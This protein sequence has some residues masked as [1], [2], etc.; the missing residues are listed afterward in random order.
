MAGMMIFRPLIEGGKTIMFTRTRRLIV[1]SLLVLGLVLSATAMPGAPAAAKVKKIDLNNATQAELE[2]LKGIGPAMAAKIIAARPFSSVDDLKNVSGIGE[3]TFAELKD[4]VTVKAVKASQATETGTT[5]HSTK[6]TETAEAAEL[7]NIN[8][9]DKAAL[10]TLPGVGPALA[11]KI[12][13]ARPFKSVAD[14]QNVSGLG[15]AKFAKIESLV[16]VE[17]PKAKRTT[18]TTKT[19]AAE[20]AVAEIVNLNTADKAALETLPGVGP[21]LADKIIAARPF[22]SVADLKSVSGLGEAKF[23]KIEGLVTVEKPKAKRTTSAETTAGTRSTSKAAAAQTAAAEILDLNTADQ[24]ALEALPG[25]GPALAEKII[26]ARP[27][28]EVGDLMNVKGIGQAKFDAIKDMVEIGQ[29]EEAVHP[30]LRPG[31]T[32]NINK[33]TQDQ[34][35]S[36]LG[37]GPV[38]AKAIIAGRPYAKIED[39][40][41]VKGIKEKTFAKLKGYIVVR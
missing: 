27:F 6:S 25:I 16:T 7:V 40:M 14:L 23:A 1:L 32:I 8:T 41:K 24:A 18:S 11:D 36:L 34:L 12:I 15:E 20:T 5:A 29:P 4:L 13:A 17:K 26:A 9:A 33:A 37:I 10:E 22:K 39:I 21:A 35:E 28:K 19:A 31:E 30:K 2:T 38:K 3:A